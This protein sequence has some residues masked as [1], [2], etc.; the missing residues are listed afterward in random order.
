MGT[1]CVVSG[2][3]VC[4]FPLFSIFILSQCTLY[5]YAICQIKYYHTI[6]Y[7]TR[8]VHTHNLQWRSE[9]EGSRIRIV[10][11]TYNLIVVGLS[12][13]GYLCALILFKIGGKSCRCLVRMIVV[14]C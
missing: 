5:C 6:P 3:I 8:T 9:T 12:G 13:D 7:S 2:H 4:L 11:E 14:C 1:L 10:S